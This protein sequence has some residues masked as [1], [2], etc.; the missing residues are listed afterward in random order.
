MSKRLIHRGF[1]MHFDEYGI[2]FV[3]ETGFLIFS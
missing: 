3:S 2:Y 1:S